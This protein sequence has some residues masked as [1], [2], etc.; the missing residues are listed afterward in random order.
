MSKA[1]DYRR[2]AAEC[3]R[4]AELVD[5][6]AA[7]ASMLAMAREWH[8]LADDIESKPER[9]LAHGPAVALRD[10]RQFTAS[11]R[12][13]IRGK[14]R[15]TLIGDSMSLAKPPHLTVPTCRG[16]APVLNEA[17]LN[18]RLIAKQLQLL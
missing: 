18:M 3:I 13:P 8:S 17:W 10:A 2:L 14:Q 12:L 4:T 16:K 9:N 1:D 11:K 6:A 7:K 15:K 5:D